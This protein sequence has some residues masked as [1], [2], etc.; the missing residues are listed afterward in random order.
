MNFAHLTQTVPKVAP[1][2]L[3]NK[4]LKFSNRRYIYTLNSLRS[5]NVIY[6]V[7]VI[8]MEETVNI[9]SAEKSGLE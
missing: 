5:D 1:V 7:L 8:I 4:L 9:L 6:S 3:C 2:E